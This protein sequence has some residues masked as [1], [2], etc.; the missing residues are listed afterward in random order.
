METADRI[1][2]HFTLKKNPSNKTY[3]FQVVC[4]FVLP[5]AKQKNTSNKKK[6]TKLLTQ[7]KSKKQREKEAN[8]LRIRAMNQRTNQEDNL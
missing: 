5:M 2:P 3:H 8:K 1:L 4:N 7:K 6:H